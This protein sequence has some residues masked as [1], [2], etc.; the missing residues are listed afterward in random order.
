MINRHRIAYYD[1][2]N[3]AAC[4]GVISM[5]ANGLTH[6]FSP[7]LSWLQAFFV[8]CVF[9]WAVPAFFMLTGATLLDYRKRYETSEFS[10][11]D[12]SSARSSPS[13]CGVSSPWQ[14]GW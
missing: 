6:S 14:S 9:Y 13:S 12:A 11:R 7:T 10:S 1:T 3:I 5:H 4:F 8:D 2:L